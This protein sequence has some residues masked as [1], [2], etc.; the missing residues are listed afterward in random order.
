MN[1][2]E[3]FFDEPVDNYIKHPH[4]KKNKIVMRTDGAA[5]GM[6]YC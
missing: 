2:Y 1:Y 6:C 5:R 3:D 4:R